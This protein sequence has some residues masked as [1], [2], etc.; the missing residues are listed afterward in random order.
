MVFFFKINNIAA[1]DA[2]T[3][4]F[5]RIELIR[6]SVINYH[7]FWPLWNPYIMSGTPFYAQSA[8]TMIDSFLGIFL[9][10]MPNAAAA[11]NMAMF[12]GI[13][14]AGIFMYIFAFYILKNHKAALV[15]SVIFVLNGSIA[16]ALGGGSLVMINAYFLIP[17]IMLFTIMSVKKR[18]W[19]RY[20]II[21]G[22]FFGFQ[23]RTGDIRL[24]SFTTLIFSLYL[25]FYIIG[26]RPLKRTL[27]A[28]LIIVIAISISFLVAAQKI[29]PAKE[30]IDLSSRGSGLSWEYVSGG[31]S[32]GLSIEKIKS[33][34]NSAIEPLYEGMPKIRRDS[35]G[36]SHIGIIAFLLGCYGIYKKR[37]NKM[38]IFLLT[39]AT[40][41]L[42]ISAGTFMHYL[43][44]KYAPLWGSYRHLSYRIL[45]IFAFAF[46]VLAGFGAKEIISKLETKNFKKRTINIISSGIILIIFFDLFIFSYNP[47]NPSEDIYKAIDDNSIMQNISRM[48]GIFRITTY[49]T[50]GIDWGT[51][52]TQVPLKI[53]HIYGYESEWYPP[54][55]N[56]YLTVAN[57]DP[58]KFWGILNMKYMTSLQEVNITGFRLLGGFTNK[59]EHYVNER[60]TQKAWGGYL[61]EN[62][63][64]IPRVI[65][66]KK[67]ILVLGS[68]DN[69]NSII[70][71]IMMHKEFDPKKMV[72]IRG[73]ETI[74]Q[75][76]DNELTK[77]SIIVLT[78]NSIDQ[79]SMRKIGYYLDNGGVLLP[80]ITKGESSISEDTI[81]NILANLNGSYDPI[82]DKD[83]KT[84]NF[85]KY[86]LTLNGKYQKGFIVL[87]E[88]F[89]VFNGWS[90]KS[91]NSEYN[92]LNANGMAS[93][94]Y[95]D[96]PVNSII[97]AYSPK[98]VVI[99]KWISAAS[100]IVIIIYF[101]FLYIRKRFKK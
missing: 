84:H 72:I 50:R 91:S 10:I 28:V 79:N 30:Y 48:P 42:M 49:E 6:Q 16:N 83:Y 93:A 44:W 82:D 29:F 81:K 40:V 87:S 98:S 92:V 27:K 19:V 45:V 80:D 70:Y 61:Y 97:F 88:K 78:P 41:S 2:L 60:D 35:P 1:T 99:G 89:S 68:N 74:N 54:Y 13:Q 95:I 94:V 36:A 77:Y 65:F 55:L 71:P 34:F 66:V 100:L 75:Y 18:E 101:C 86:E 22:I 59:K 17:L 15:S 39:L 47:E 76:D 51:E 37:K 58:A 31:D 63:F 24:F 21:T 69:Q 20:A 64:F 14:L 23:I 7:H 38:V 26:G 9:L 73:K 33:L 46:S 4:V 11:L 3:F 67:S 32:A 90:A 43:L 53:Q 56:I 52:F 62:E 25:L 57:Q 96:K 12:A 8:T 85:D 5:H